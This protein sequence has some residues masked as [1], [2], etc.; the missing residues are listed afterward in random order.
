MISLRSQPWWSGGLGW[1]ALALTF[2]A[3]PEIARATEPAGQRQK[4]KVRSNT[5]TPE[6]V[7]IQKSRAK[8]P[9]SAPAGA[10]DSEPKLALPDEF[11]LPNDSPA[12]RPESTAETSSPAPE[13]R[14]GNNVAPSTGTQST[15]GSVTPP[16][17]ERESVESVAPP[18][19]PRAQPPA[20]VLPGDPLPDDVASRRARA[21]GPSFE[22]EITVRTA[23]E[24]TPPPPLTYKGE[25]APPDR[26][27]LFSLSYRHF[28][29]VD[30]LDRRQNWHMLGL[31]ITPLRNYARLNLVTE[32]GF[33]GGEAAANGDKGDFFL[34]ESVGIGVQYPFWVTPFIE[35]QV[36]F[37]VGR[38]ELFERNDLALMFNTGLF[39]GAQ[40]AMAKGVYLM[41]AVGW[42]RPHIIPVGTSFAEAIFFN[43]AT[44]K[45]GVGF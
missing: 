42:A 12:N 14:A 44:F 4:I 3:S 41:S 24:R 6:T 15:S 23:I 36:G 43:R 18:E 22:N 11:Q 27:A 17:A 40:W 39:V 8:Q 5:S 38:T 7:P 33:E 28:S 45:V 32:I 37:G 1:A 13:S 20:D 25:R 21:S 29:I 19:D 9:Q 34:V 10:P 2:I 31:E 35:F 16:V 30:G 26:S